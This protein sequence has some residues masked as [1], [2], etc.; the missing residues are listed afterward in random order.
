MTKK[1]F[2]SLDFDGCL[3]NE[4]IDNARAFHS[5]GNPKEDLTLEHLITINQKLID[6]L[7]SQAKEF[8]SSTV[9]L[10]SD[11]QDYKKEELNS[12][13]EGQY[14]YPFMVDFA[15][16]ISAEFDSVLMAD[17]YNDLAPGESFRQALQDYHSHEKHEQDP[18][19]QP[20]PSKLTLLYAQM[21]KAATENP[22]DI[23]T[24]EFY[25]D[26][27]DILLSLQE[28][29]N[30]NP[31]MIPKNITLYLNHYDSVN[32]Q[33]LLIIQ[34]EGNPDSQYQHTLKNPAYRKVSANPAEAQADYSISELIKENFPKISKSFS[35]IK[36][37]LQQ[38][39]LPKLKK[40]LIREASSLQ[41]LCY[42]ASMK[43]NQGP[44]DPKNLTPSEAATANADTA[45]DDKLAQL[46]NLPEHNLLR[47]EIRPENDNVC[48]EDIWS[49]AL[50][51]KKSEGKKGLFNQASRKQDNENKKLFSKP[52][53]GTQMLMYLNH[54]KKQQELGQPSSPSLDDLNQL[55]N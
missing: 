4:N 23:V 30:S 45:L 21:H 2:I 40:S 5:P 33:N 27:T 12:N 48:P 42:F 44:L 3:Y 46:L 14:C 47:Q 53:D 38:L 7:D 43:Q 9:F 17:I 19:T 6:H 11:R 31:H 34:G 8:A 51:K 36:L 50:F 25:D 26:R 13:R 39:N 28:I 20:D 32:L 41:D 1:R 35:Q 24:Y 55:L 52:G 49:Y 37:E 18:Q 16:K 29:F 10:G 22:N 54:L 15:K